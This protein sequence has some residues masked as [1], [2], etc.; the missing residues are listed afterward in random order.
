MI[1]VIITSKNE[2]K[3]IGRAAQAFLDEDYLGDKFEVIVIAPDKAT[4]EAAKNTGVKVLEDTGKG[5]PIALN[6]A[7]QESRGDTL[8]FSDG[9]VWISQGAVK[10]LLKNFENGVVTGHPVVDM[11]TQDKFGFWQDSLI[12]RADCIRKEKSSHHQFI[13]LS[14]YLFAVKKDYLDNFKFPNNL[15]TEDEYLSYYLWHQGHKI[16]YAANATV[17][18]KFAK[19]YKD[20]LNQKVRTLGGSYQIPKEWKKNIAMRSF[21]RESKYGPSFLFTYGHSLKQKYWVIL[22]LFARLHAWSKA[23]LSVR[24]FKKDA[25]VLWKRVESTK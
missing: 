18:V 4:Q 1:S 24:I 16:A 15:L 10:E 19:N 13:N 21:L 5:K 12:D 11:P 25:S 3:T 7:I 6:L 23:F 9:E 20:W 14:G 8:I 22:L 17:N 2:P